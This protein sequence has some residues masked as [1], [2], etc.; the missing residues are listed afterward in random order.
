MDFV[1]KILTV[2]LFFSLNFVSPIFALGGDFPIENFDDFDCGDLFSDDND[3]VNDFLNTT[4]FHVK[5]QADPS[6]IVSIL[7]DTFKIDQLLQEDLFLKTSHLNA[8]SLLDLPIFIADKTYCFDDWVAGFHLFYNE[9]SRM[10][11]SK[12]SS[13]ADC[14]LAITQESLLERLDLLINEIRPLLPSSAAERLQFLFDLGIRQAACLFRRATPQERRTGFMFHGM[15]YFD[16]WRFK[17]K[18]PLYYRERNLFLTR[19]ER[20]AIEAVFGAL[21]PEDEGDL[22]AKHLISDRFGFGNLRLAFDYPVFSDSG[23]LETRLGLFSTVPLA[24]SIVKG[25]AGRAFKKR[26][27]RSELNLEELINLVMSPEMQCEAQ[28]VAQDFFLDALD[29][30]SSVLLDTDLGN[31]RHFG[32]GFVMQSKWPLRALIKRYWAD[33][34]II[35]SK[36]TLEYLFPSTE[37]RFFIEKRNPDE[38]ANRD[39]SDDAMARDNLAFLEKKFVDKF[40][41]YVYPTKVYPGMIFMWASK[42]TYERERWGAHIGWDT[43]VQSREKLK[44]ICAPKCQL[45]KLDVAKSTRCFAYQWDVFGSIFY[46]AK[47]PNRDYLFS[48][49][50]ETAMDTKGI[51]RHFTASLNFES[52][53]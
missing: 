38:F 7:V 17:F 37:Q 32:L 34:I 20:R 6:S 49:N 35:K 10:F 18:I 27:R 24:V 3:V 41:P 14:Y 19:K 36:M 42:L 8:R 26:R 43:W 13:C 2:F 22:A 4:E 47:R 11:Y 48:L 1:K 33:R 12:E 21:S 46:R 30:I 45:K 15:R 28:S 39:F 23:D 9:T 44:K 29:G 53:F 51:G 52:N 31:H 40:F 16:C 25:I 50:L 5:R